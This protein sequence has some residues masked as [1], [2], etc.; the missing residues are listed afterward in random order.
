MAHQER[1]DAPWWG[2]VAAP[3]ARGQRAPVAGASPYRRSAMSRATIFSTASRVAHTLV[4]LE[5]FDEGTQNLR[6]RDPRR[7]D[8]L[9]APTVR[10]L[11]RGNPSPSLGSGTVHVGAVRDAYDDDELLIGVESKQ[12]PVVTAARRAQAGQL[13][14]QGFAH[15]HRVGGQGDGDELRDRRGVLVRQA[16]ER[17]LGGGAENNPPTAVLWDAH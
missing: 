8:L 17:S 6:L 9:A 2:V 15:P 12:Y 14:A 7:M 13:V 1:P 5:T 11:G 16:H 4:V 3:F 10:R